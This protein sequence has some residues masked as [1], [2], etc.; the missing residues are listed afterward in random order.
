LLARVHV[1][2][3]VVFPRPQPPEARF[4]V[5]PQD[6][7]F[8][9][10]LVERPPERAAVL[11]SHLGVRPREPQARRAP[12]RRAPRRS[13]RTRFHREPVN[14]RKP[15]DPVSS[16]RASRLARPI[17]NDTERPT[18]PT[19]GRG[20]ATPRSR[21]RPKPLGAAGGN[22]RIVPGGCSR[23]KGVRSD[24]SPTVCGEQFSKALC[25]FPPLRA[26]DLP[27]QTLFVGA[28]VGVDLSG[29]NPTSP[30]IVAGRRQHDRPDMRHTRL[31][32]VR[33]AA[34]C[35]ARC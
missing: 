29:E 4:P 17:G 15:S 35:L 10:R 25:A 13:S 24:A 21:P 7:E 16:K 20:T 19:S 23:E 9:T 1:I 27:L 33:T 8:Q 6:R 3:A 2:E 34:N 22:R 12:G 26:N 32:T 5:F 14:P 28:F 11:L 31:E 18:S 30:P